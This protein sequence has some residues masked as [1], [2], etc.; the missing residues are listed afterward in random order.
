MKF[1]A[2]DD[3]DIEVPHDTCAH[4]AR[5]TNPFK[6]NPH[7]VTMIVVVSKDEAGVATCAAALRWA[8]LSGGKG[9]G[10]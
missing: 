10:G 2:E 3:G 8:G 1:G 9:R 5:H 6:H 7:P 4:A